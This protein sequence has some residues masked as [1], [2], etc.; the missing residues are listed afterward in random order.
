LVL[1]VFLCD[2]LFHFFHPVDSTPDPL[3]LGSLHSRSACPSAQVA[4]AAVR[5]I[6][7][8][9]RRRIRLDSFGAQLS[10][11]LPRLIK[12]AARLRVMESISLLAFQL[13][14]QTDDGLL[15]RLQSRFSL[16]KLLPHLLDQALALLPLPS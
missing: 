1:Q 12:E 6:I 7:E 11:R 2:S 15:V 3:V 5:N 16:L 4:T 10:E 8:N 9:P 14:R 13:L